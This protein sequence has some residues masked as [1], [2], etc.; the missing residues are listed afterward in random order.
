MVDDILA[1]IT[2]LTQKQKCTKFVVHVKGLAR[3]PK[4]EIESISEIALSDRVVKVEFRISGLHSTVIQ[5]ILDVEMTSLRKVLPSA[6]NIE[7]APPSG[8]T[9]S[10]HDNPSSLKS[11]LDDSVSDAANVRESQPGNNVPVYTLDLHISYQ[12]S[13]VDLPRP[14][15]TY[16]TLLD[17]TGVTNLNVG[18]ET[19]ISDD[20]KTHDFPLKVNLN[21]SRSRD[22][23]GVVVNFDD[24]SVQR[25]CILKSYGDELKT[26]VRH[27]TQS[28]VVFG[29]SNSSVMKGALEVILH[30]RVSGV[31]STPTEDDMKSFLTGKHMS[32]SPTQYR[33]LQ[34]PRLWGIGITVKCFFERNSK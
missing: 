11:F 12:H 17:S 26:Y 7:V 13:S 16:T 9:T 2:I 21:Q 28:H 32:L 25:K 33:R 4:F 27:R 20:G 22:E 29:N 14:I 31:G 8:T 1:W 15:D 24:V 30:A 6:N 34:N 5:H 19:L 18:V 10:S 23:D 3:M